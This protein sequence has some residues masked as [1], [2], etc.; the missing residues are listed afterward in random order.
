MAS[1]ST[2]FPIRLFSP[3]N[4]F[5]FRDLASSGMAF[6]GMRPSAVPSS[7]YA[8]LKMNSRIR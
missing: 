7:T 5:R 2:I 1:Q 8:G 4:D 3:T 6:S